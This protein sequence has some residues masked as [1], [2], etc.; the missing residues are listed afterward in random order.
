MIEIDDSGV[1]GHQGNAI[2]RVLRVLVVNIRSVL[3]VELLVQSDIVIA[4]I[5]CQR[6]Q[7]VRN[8]F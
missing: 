3:S 1:R 7:L 4:Y 6:V 8:V 2:I 5:R